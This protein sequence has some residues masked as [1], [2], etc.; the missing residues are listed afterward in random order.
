MTF[1]EFYIASRDEIFRRLAVRISDTDVAAEAVDE[2]MERAFV[3]WPRVSGMS[4][5]E[6]WV[7]RVAYRWAIDRLRRQKTERRILPRL[8]TRDSSFPDI[9]PRLDGA[10][11]NISGDQRAVVVLAHAFDWTEREIAETLEIPVGTVKSRIHRGLA[12]LRVEIGA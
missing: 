4:N 10:L 3:R 12:A 5:P 6:G 9:E 11:E 8:I 7:Y 2:A 1:D